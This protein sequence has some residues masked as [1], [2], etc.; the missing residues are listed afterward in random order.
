MPIPT[1]SA[2]AVQCGGVAS[3]GMVARYERWITSYN[4]TAPF[5]SVS[6][7][8]AL[9]IVQ[10]KLEQ[11]QDLH[12][13]TKL[14]VQHVIE[15]L[16]LCLHYTYFILKDRYYKQVEDVAMGFLVIPIIANMYMEHFEEKPLGTVKSFPRFQRMYVDDTFIIQIAEHKRTSSDPSAA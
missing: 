10:N 5:T 7:T 12:L 16:G 2:K 8:T 13:R 15:L 14:T 3:S 11:D 9:N 4:V 6:L 1:L